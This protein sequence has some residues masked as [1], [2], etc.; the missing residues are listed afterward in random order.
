MGLIFSKQ[1]KDKIE[2]SQKQKSIDQCRNNFRSN[3]NKEEQLA[4]EK[5]FIC[6]RFLKVQD[7]SNPTDFLNG[8]VTESYALAENKPSSEKAVKQLIDELSLIF[9]E[10]IYSS[11]MKMFI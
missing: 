9:P 1:K 7:T 5:I 6:L 8:I 10:K 3:L 2:V 4:A 11:S